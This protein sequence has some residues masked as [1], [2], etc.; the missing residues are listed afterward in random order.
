VH[1]CIS[2]A[3]LS[4]FLVNGDICTS[5]TC[6]SMAVVVTQTHYNVNVAHLGDFSQSSDA[7]GVI[8]QATAAST[9]GPLQLIIHYSCYHSALYD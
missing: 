8:P 6:I 9:Q 2:A 3:R 5:T 7:N 1:C 4:T